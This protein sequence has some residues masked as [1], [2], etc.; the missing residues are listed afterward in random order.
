MAAGEYAKGLYTSEKCEE[1]LGSWD[2]PLPKSLKLTNR[3]RKLAAESMVGSWL[4]ND[5]TFPKVMEN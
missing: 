5:S 4:L 2:A 3:K 1:L